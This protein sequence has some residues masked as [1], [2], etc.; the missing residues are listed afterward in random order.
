VKNQMAELVR[1][2]APVRVLILIGDRAPCVTCG[3]TYAFHIEAGTSSAACEE[4][5]DHAPGCSTQLCE[6]G[7][8]RAELCYACDAASRLEG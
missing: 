1:L 4:T 7:K 5:Y 3:G 6:H 2:Q 8:P